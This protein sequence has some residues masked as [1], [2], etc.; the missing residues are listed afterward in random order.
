MPSGGIDTPTKVA[1]SR[2]E[3]SNCRFLYSSS[4]AADDSVGMTE[5][6]AAG[7]NGRAY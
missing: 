2:E 7:R 3:K 5:F 4:G 1:V 6:I